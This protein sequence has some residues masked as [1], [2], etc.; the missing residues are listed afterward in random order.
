LIRARQ[1][2][3][4]TTIARGYEQA[5]A[6]AISVLCDGPGFGGTPLDLRRVA[7]AVACPLLFKEFV[8]DV[9]QLDQARAMGASLVLLL[10]R[11]LSDD[12]LA[13]LT[14][15]TQRRGMQPVVEAADAVELARALRL[16]APIVGVNARDLRSFDVDP[17]Q[18]ARLVDRIP[19][20]RVAVFMSGVRSCDD[21]RRVRATRA[22]AVLVGEGLMRAEDPGRRL[23]ELLA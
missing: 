15:E 7:A 22:D 11:V 2:G 5:G 4:L 14:H 17:D 23:A 9:L 21:M 1:A 16:D 18:A 19:S 3:G 13:M 6:S 12:E 10:V 20:D 8:V